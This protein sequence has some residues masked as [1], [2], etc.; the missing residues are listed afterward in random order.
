MQTT[1]F[2]PKDY[3][4]IWQVLASTFAILLFWIFVL[5]MKFK[6]PVAEGGNMLEDDTIDGEFIP[7]VKHLVWTI[8]PFLLSL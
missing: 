7:L 1:N 5:C 8:G 6:T 3:S 2:I 4:E